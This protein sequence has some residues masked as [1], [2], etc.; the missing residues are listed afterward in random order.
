[1]PVP[2]ENLGMERPLPYRFSSRSLLLLGGW[3][4]AL[5][6]VARACSQVS[7]FESF[8]ATAYG[9]SLHPVAFIAMAVL[10][11]VTVGHCCGGVKGQLIGACGGLLLGGVAWISLL[12][13]LVSLT[14][15][16]SLG[17]WWA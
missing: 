13:G 15:S 8:P 3:Y 17:C 14:L 6:T 7:L 1:M 11:G 4:A 9:I 16:T 2:R 10:G 12:P 5:L